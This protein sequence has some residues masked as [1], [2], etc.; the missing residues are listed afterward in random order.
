MSACG[1]SHSFVASRFS[2]IPKRVDLADSFR[3]AERCGIRAA[4]RNIGI[5]LVFFVSRDALV[6]VSLTS[7]RGD[8]EIG[9]FYLIH[10]RG[11][12]LY[13]QDLWVA[14]VHQFLAFTC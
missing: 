1:R 11:S 9:D 8:L 10:I 12:N 5:V 3:F 13:I 2:D 7:R 6:D 4:N 14:L